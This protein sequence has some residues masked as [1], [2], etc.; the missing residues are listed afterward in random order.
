MVLEVDAAH[1][2]TVTIGEEAGAPERK[3][4]LTLALVA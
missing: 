2:L 4:Y 3:V 1:V